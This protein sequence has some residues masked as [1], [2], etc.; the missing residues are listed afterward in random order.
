MSAEQ[1]QS[2]PRLDLKAVLFLVVT[3]GLAAAVL[4][5][6]VAGGQ[7]VGVVLTLT[8]VVLIAT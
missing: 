1:L 2:Q 7:R 3:V 4:R 8:G 6:R 5:E